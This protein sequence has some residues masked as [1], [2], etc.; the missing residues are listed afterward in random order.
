MHAIKFH[1]AN[2]DYQA[3]EISQFDIKNLRRK[4]I[5]FA[6]AAALAI[7]LICK[8]ILVSGRFFNGATSIELTNISENAINETMAKHLANL[9]MFDKNFIMPGNTKKLNLRSLIQKGN[10]RIVPADTHTISIIATGKDKIFVRNLL[11][12]ITESYISDTAERQ[13]REFENLTR[14]QQAELEKYRKLN[15]QYQLVK[16]KLT[17][18]AQTIPNERFDKAIIKYTQD[19][20]KE[21][22]L[23]EKYVNQLSNL[24]QKISQIRAELRNPTIQIDPKK[25]EQARKNNRLYTGDYNMLKL[26]HQAYLYY[27]KKEAKQLSNSISAL[28]K[29]LQQLSQNVSKRLDMNL[30]EE[31][32]DDLLELNLAAELYEGKLARFQE[33]WTRYFNKLL[34]LISDPK[35][36]DFSSIIT[37]LSQLRQNLLKGAGQLP[38]KLYQLSKKLQR[39]KKNRTKSGLSKILIRNVARSNVTPQLDK[40]IELWN[41]TIFHLNRLFPDGNVRLKTL[42][43][44][45][46]RLQSRLKITDKNIKYKLER[47]QLIRKKHILQRQLVGLQLE[48]EQ[49]S[50]MLINTYKKISDCQTKLNKLGK[51]WPE[52]ENLKLASINLEG[53]LNLVASQLKHKN[54]SKPS[55]EHLKAG[56]ILITARNHFGIKSENEFWVAFIVSVITFGIIAAIQ[57]FFTPKFLIKR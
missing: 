53:Q 9:Q 40:C 45:C 37:V 28:R 34:E 12:F 14:R 41:Q 8:F 38:T 21:I 19:I 32:T 49:T 57:L 4:I 1:P 54:I 30:P 24:N 2:D 36:A 13:R 7:G 56:P 39:G 52:W 20:Q 23:S 26:K 27:F 43:R 51:A 50:R 31:L 5:L 42:S 16:E 18:L 22:T 29:A 55:T 10:I 46:S 11:K 35:Q 25:L 17:K 6:I 44:I 47:E 33:R 3:K 15:K 48:F